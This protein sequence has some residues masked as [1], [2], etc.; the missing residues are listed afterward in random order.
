VLDY[1]PSA[2][3]RW[4]VLARPAK[5][6]GNPA[7][8]AAFAS[9]V[10]PERLDAYQRSTGVDL[11]KLPSASVAGYDL[12]TLYLAELPS[13]DAA[14]IRERFASRLTQ[15]GIVKQVR[16]D[17]YRVSGTEKDTPLALVTVD[18]HLVAYASGDLTLARIVE[19]YA[20]RKLKSPTAL[21]GAALSSFEPAADDVVIAFY[22]P[23]PF[24]SQSLATAPRLLSAS[25]GLAVTIKE[26]AGSSLPVTATL[27][28]DWSDSPDA[29]D[30]LLRVWTHLAASSTGRLLGL[31]S[32]QKVETSGD[33]ARLQISVELGLAPLVAGLRALTSANVP[34]IFDLFDKKPDPLPAPEP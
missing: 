4:L 15:G 24:S 8:S 16:P 12:G 7:L 33:R 2:G 19:A 11:R 32:A 18:N 14:V 6:A 25:T 13:P 22:A 3:L 29:R 23:G 26:P 27:A 9:L 31:D 17:I 21:H 5:I 20:E 34:E 30:E 28:G 10:P 1:A